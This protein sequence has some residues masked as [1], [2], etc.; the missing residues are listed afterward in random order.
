MNAKKFIK[1]DQTQWSNEDGSVHS[2]AVETSNESLDLET[3]FAREEKNIMWIKGNS[4]ELVA[5]QVIDVVDKINKGKL[6]TYRAFS[7]TPFYD[8]QDPDI[9]PTTEEVLVPTRYSSVKLCVAEQYN[10]LNRQFVTPKVVEQ[11]EVIANEA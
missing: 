11:P 6:A 4:A 8:G 3:G 7:A 1:D 2:A 9:N 10:A 5:K